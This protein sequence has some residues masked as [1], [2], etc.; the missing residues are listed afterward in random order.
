[1]VAIASLC[2]R[3]VGRSYGMASIEMIFKLMFSGFTYDFYVFL[4]FENGSQSLPNDGVIISQENSYL[5]WNSIRRGFHN[6]IGTVMIIL[7]PRL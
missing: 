2:G 5:L 3:M 1:M 7:V 6:E 4:R